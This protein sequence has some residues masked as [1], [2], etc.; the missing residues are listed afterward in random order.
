M[1]EEIN[2]YVR[3]WIEKADEDRLVIHQLK[4]A[5][6]SAK[7]AM[8]KYGEQTFCCLL[9]QLQCYSS[10]ANS[11]VLVLHKF[12]HNGNP[13]VVESHKIKTRIQAADVDPGC[14]I[15]YRFR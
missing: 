10:P 8:E 12:Q 5:N 9:L 1:T 6:S 3:Q 14:F 2:K 15:D 7:G 13:V 4:E 11:Y